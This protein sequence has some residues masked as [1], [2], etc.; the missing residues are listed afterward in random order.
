M[1]SSE[2]K[3]VFSRNKENISEKNTLWKLIMGNI[4]P[5]NQSPRPAKGLSM[6]SDRNMDGTDC[7]NCLFFC[8]VAHSI[9]F[10][11]S[12]VV[13]KSANCMCEQQ[14]CRS[15][16]AS[17]HS[18]QRFYWW[19]LGKDSYLG[20]CMPKFVVFSLSRPVVFCLT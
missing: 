1:C 4:Q 15:A 11:F 2:I 14:R 5:K 17:T 13:R 20:C 9:F 7:P 12:L 10:L 18:D 6:H 19:L 8:V 3:T 16:C